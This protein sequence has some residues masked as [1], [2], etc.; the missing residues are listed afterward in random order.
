[1]INLFRKIASKSSKEN[2]VKTIFANPRK[3]RLLDQ[4]RALSIINT[5]QHSVIATEM[6]EGW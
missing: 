1:M 3:Q 6:L 2:Q 5:K 4:R